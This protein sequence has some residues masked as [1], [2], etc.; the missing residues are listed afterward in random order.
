LFDQK[1]A[2][3]ADGFAYT[4]ARGRNT[5]KTTG[6]DP[7]GAGRAIIY[8]AG[9]YREIVSDGARN[10]Q[11]DLPVVTSTPQNSLENAEIFNVVTLGADPTGVEDSAPAFRSAAGSNRIILVPP[12][13]YRFASDQPVPLPYTALGKPAVLFQGLTNFHM[14]LTEATIT[15][16]PA[17]ASAGDSIFMIDRSNNF[18][19][20]GGRYS[21]TVLPNVENVAYALENDQNFTFD[22][23]TL[24]GSWGGVGAPFNGNWLVHGLFSNLRLYGVGQCVDF[25]QVHDVI[26]KSIV[27]YGAGNSQVGPGQKCF[28]FL[29]DALFTGLNF[30]GKSWSNI[31]EGVRIVDSYATNFEVVF[32][33]AAGSNYVFNGNRLDANP[34]NPEAGRSAYPVLLYY[35]PRGQYSSVGFPVSNVVISNNTFTNNGNPATHGS[36][37]FLANRNIVNSDVIS[38]II[39]TGNVFDNNDNTAISS[40]SFSNLARV[41]AFDNIFRGVRQTQ[42]IAPEVASNTPDRDSSLGNLCATNTALCRTD[43]P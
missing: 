14:I 9:E 28:S 2:P 22:D 4:H 24:I 35:I 18:S 42:H 32:V 43:A 31:N 19:V 39:I 6:V 33:P 5:P 23:I 29:N 41:I 27:A 8:G 34:G 13:E 30:T 16:D 38:D 10:V 20:Q 26:L 37:I 7:K 1:N 11:R 17:L 25:G 40:G 3:L 15:L 12:G 36:A 21:A